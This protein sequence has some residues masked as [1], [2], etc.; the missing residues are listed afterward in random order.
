MMFCGKPQNDAMCSLLAP[1][2]TSFGE[3]IIMPE[4]HIMFRV[5]G[6]HHLVCP[7]VGHMDAPTQDIETEV[8]LYLFIIYL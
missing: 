6:T 3:A 7:C 1:Q 8:I 2:G 5:S 4:G